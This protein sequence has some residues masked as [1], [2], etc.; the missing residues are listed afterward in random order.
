MITKEQ[1][2]HLNNSCNHLSVVGRRIDLRVASSAPRLGGKDSRAA[3][4]LGQYQTSRYRGVGSGE[5]REDSR[6]AQQERKVDCTINPGTYRTST[7]DARPTRD[8]ERV[9]GD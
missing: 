1:Y 5:V 9:V 3:G 6:G 2:I 8:V 7:S 4:R